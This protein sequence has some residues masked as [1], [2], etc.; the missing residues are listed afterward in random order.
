MPVAGEAKVAV[1][2]IHLA[3]PEAAEAVLEV[4]ADAAG[5]PGEVIGKPAVR[6]LEAAPPLWIDFR[7]PS[8]IA[9][10]GGR[11]WL[12]LRANKGTLLWFADGSAAGA[13]MLSTDQGRTWGVPE[14]PIAAA[15][16]LMAQ[17][18]L[19]SGSRNAALA[20]PVLR[21]ERDGTVLDGNL[22]AQAVAGAGG[23]YSVRAAQFSVAALSAAADA[24][25]DATGKVT[26]R[27]ALASTAIADVTIEDF[28]LTYDPG[29]PTGA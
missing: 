2:R 3:A 26:K 27:F 12:A 5:S 16:N 29:Q 6:Q 24:T 14:F 23:E 28:V 7:L 15:A 8:P 18:L 1:A 22:L 4:H 25:E 17:I 10:E 9:V 19:D 21:L 20:P 13:P 11:L